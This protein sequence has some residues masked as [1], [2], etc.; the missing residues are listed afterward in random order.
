MVLANSLSAYALVMRQLYIGAAVMWNIIAALSGI[1]EFDKKIGFV[2][3][4]LILRKQ[5]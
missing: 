4:F 3:N 1:G 2:T 5:V